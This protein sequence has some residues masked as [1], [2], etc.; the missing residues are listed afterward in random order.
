M[1]YVLEVS[2]GQTLLGL[3]AKYALVPVEATAIYLI[4]YIEVWLR[5][6]FGLL[7]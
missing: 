7:R 3:V 5:T 1:N 4:A 6:Y 2:G